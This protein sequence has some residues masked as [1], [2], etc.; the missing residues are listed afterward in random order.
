[1]S[2]FAVTAGKYSKNKRKKEDVELI[3]VFSDKKSA[4]EYVE[5]LMAEDIDWCKIHNL[6][7]QMKEL[8]NEI[9]CNR[10]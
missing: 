5:K 2:V 8:E 1:M 4:K 10:S 6:T 9:S 3:K 7:K